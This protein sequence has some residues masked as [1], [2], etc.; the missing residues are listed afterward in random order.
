VNEQ[1]TYN[2]QSPSTNPRDIPASLALLQAIVLASP[3]YPTFE[4]E[5]VHPIM[6]KMSVTLL[7]VIERLITDPERDYPVLVRGPRSFL[8]STA[9]DTSCVIWFVPS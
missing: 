2:P 3:S 4:R 5:A 1:D 7:K 8:Q 9:L 6:G